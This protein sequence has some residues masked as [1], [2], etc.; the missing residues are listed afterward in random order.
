MVVL[1]GR[2]EPEAGALL[3][4]ALAAAREAVYQRTRVPS[5]DA[6]PVGVSAETPTMTQQQ[7]DALALLAETTLA[8]SS[9]PCRSSKQGAPPASYA[10]TTVLAAGP[11]PIRE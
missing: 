2:L 10:S 8:Q 11:P 5:G 4:Q 9:R 3:V 6:G 7:A 1:R